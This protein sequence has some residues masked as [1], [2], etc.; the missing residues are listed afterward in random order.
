MNLLFTYGGIVENNQD[1]EK[2]GRLKVRVPHVYGTSGDAGRYIG[3]NDLPWALPAGM[4]N[5]SKKS[6]GGFS[7]IPEV[8]DKV[9]VRFLDGEPEKPIW[10]WG[11]QTI[12]ERKNFPLHSYKLGKP[13]NGVGSP[14]RAAWF[15]WS[16]G[17]EI[18]EGSV[19]A[20]T[21]QGYSV[22]LTDASA[23]GTNDGN[24]K[25]STALGQML[26]LDDADFSGLLLVNE[27]MNFQ[28]F[29]D[30]VAFAANYEFLATAGDF[31]VDADI[32]AFTVRT[33][34]GINLNTVK[35]FKVNAL[36]KAEIKALST[37]TINTIGSLNLLFSKLTLG[38]SGAEPYVLGNQLTA[39]MNSLL[40]YLSTHTHSNGNNGSPTGPPIIP[41]NSVVQPQPASVTS[42][43]IFGL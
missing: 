37:I 38:L 16:N 3:T 23:Q 29:N 24:T 35:D 21:S 8:N 39:W 20:T 27:D 25:M 12:D 31:T 4:P 40:T 11:M 17:I 2:L 41:P 33:G 28:I 14:D 34:M 13:P 5:G 6:S 19:I 43:V 15:K 30:W 36:L 9:W 7:H 18:N 1:P 26:K 42:K 10:E 22:I 32:G